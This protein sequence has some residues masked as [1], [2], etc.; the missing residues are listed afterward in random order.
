M[1]LIQDFLQPLGYSSFVGRGAFVHDG[2]PMIL[3][4]NYL[5]DGESIYIRTVGGTMLSSL[6]GTDVAFE[7]DDSRPQ[8]HAG[9]S[10][11]VQGSARSVNDADEIEWLE[12][13]PLRSWAWRGA[14]H[15]VRMSIETA[16]GRRLPEG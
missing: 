3:P 9:W 14:D 16:S 11:V 8:A 13:G 6:D 1:M 12:R 2:R 5:L 7:V 10:V 4:A 15:W